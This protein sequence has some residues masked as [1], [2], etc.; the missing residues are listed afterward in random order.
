MGGGVLRVMA[1]CLLVLT[2][3]VQLA[4]T[5]AVGGFVSVAPRGISAFQGWHASPRHAPGLGIALRLP[6]SDG[7]R[8]VQAQ[9]GPLCG[10]HM[11]RAKSGDH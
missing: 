5:W 8:R 7:Q 4:D 3:C 9:A 11:A 2:I 6:G 1:K 10:F